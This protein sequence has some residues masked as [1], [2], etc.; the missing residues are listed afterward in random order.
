M[1]LEFCAAKESWYSTW[2]PGV[3]NGELAAMKV[4]YIKVWAL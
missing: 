4:D 2:K 3:A 1:P